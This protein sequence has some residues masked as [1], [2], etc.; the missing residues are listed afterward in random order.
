PNRIAGTAHEMEPVDAHQSVPTVD[1]LVIPLVRPVP[2]LRAP[3]AVG[4]NAKAG[5]RQP[6]A[7]IENLFAR[8]EKEVKVAVADG[9]NAAQ[10]AGNKVRDA[11]RGQKL[12]LHV[13]VEIV[14]ETD[15]RRRKALR[16]AGPRLIDLKIA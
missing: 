7:A 9:R 15:G 11:R 5:S 3:I 16:R 14:F 10:R 4:R 8:G 6:V 12:R 13:A 2:E 1:N